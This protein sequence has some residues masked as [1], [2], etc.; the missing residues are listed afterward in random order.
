[1]AAGRTV[2]EG[3]AGPVKEVVADLLGDGCQASDLAGYVII[4]LSR[5]G[6]RIASNAHNDAGELV[7][8]R[9]IV[10]SLEANLAEGGGR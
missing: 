1:M 6:F 7:I 4:G 2:L 5:T 9:D 10:K 3:M 8:L